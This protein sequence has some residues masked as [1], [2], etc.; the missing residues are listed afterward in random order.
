MREINFSEISKAVETLFIDA[1]CNI[2][3][4]VENSIRD[5]LEREESEAGKSVLSQI[6]RNMEYARGEG[7]PIC[8]DTGAA[9]V[10]LEIGQ[11]VHITGGYIYGA[12]NDGV[13]HGYTNGYLRKSMVK[14]PIDRVNTQ[15]NTPAIIHTEIVPG[16][17]I[18]I[19]AV[20]KGFGSENMSAVKMLK[21]S[22]GR[23]GVKKFVLETVLNAGSN[24]CPP[25][26]LGIG[27]G[28]TFELCALLAKKAL[29]REL[30]TD[31]QDP[32]LSSLE[33]EI[34]NDVNDTG[35]GPQGLGGRVTCLGVHILSYPTH[36][37]GL[38]VA[39]NIQCHVSRHKSIL[40]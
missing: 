38:P 7:I 33:K 19:T 36:I 15:D 14:S 17:R 6:I 26:I 28:G 18:K 31:N 4:D 9:V 37:A 21:P 2:C 10:F 1:C 16:D 8:Q 23:E 11:D 39:V 3:P 22:D 25:I 40:L 5:G 24:P 35:I 20:P 30:G 13:R 29:L 27:L 12:I 32:A 34:I